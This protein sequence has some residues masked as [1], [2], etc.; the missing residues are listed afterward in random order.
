MTFRFED[1]NNDY[2]YEIFSLEN[3]EQVKFFKVGGGGGAVWLSRYGFPYMVGDREF[4][5]CHHCTPCERR[6]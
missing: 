6:V 3:G 4:N 5:G 2:A 1:E